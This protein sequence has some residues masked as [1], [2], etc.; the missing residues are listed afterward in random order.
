[1]L[2]HL[3]R[4]RGLI[5]QFTTRLLQQRYRGSYLGMLWPLLTPLFMLAVY[6]FVFAV[7]F[8]AR[9]TGAPT[10]SRTDFAL[11]LFAGLMAFNVFGESATAAPSLVV[12][13]PNYVRKVVFPLEVLPVSQVLAAIVHSLFGLAV[14]VAAQ[15]LLTHRVSP[16]LWA[17]PIVYVPLTLFTLGVAW[18]LSSLGVF[19]RD[20]GQIIGVAVQML[21]FLT[22]IFYP[23]E[24]VPA[25]LRPWLAANPLAFVVDWARRTILLGSLPPLVEW[26]V[27]TVCTAA[28]CWLGYVWFMKS[29]P[30]FADVL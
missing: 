21:F 18:F 2:A 19:V 6:T 16:T 15:A 7:V 30:A 25:S 10:D 20:V 28:V 17:L 12:S 5:R 3:W 8:R 26:V 23:A 14:L 27:V 13:N 11:M 1:M 9:W 22:P 24:A 4:Y 29:K